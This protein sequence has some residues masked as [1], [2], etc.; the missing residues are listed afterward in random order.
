MARPRTILGL[1]EGGLASRRQGLRAL[2]RRATGG[3]DP[4][5]VHDVRVALRRLEALARLF[6]GLPS[7]GDG[8]EVRGAARELRRRLSLLRSEEVGRALLAARAS[9]EDEA[10][11]A[12][13]FPGDPPSAR[14]PAGELE[15]VERVAAA[16]QRR[17]ATALGRPFSPRSATEAKLLART[18]RRLSRR[19]SELARLLP[20]RVETLHAARIAAKRA[21][22][23][24]EVVEPLVPRAGPL[25]G[26]LRGFQDAA[27]NAH[28]LLELARRVR[29]AVSPGD[30]S[31]PGSF[32]GRLETECA[33]AA[34]SA[35]RRGEA[36]AVP[37]RKLRT[38]LRAPGSR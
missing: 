1:V 9:G 36:L 5:L 30:A 22:Y 35:R 4:E 34:G 37:V 33:K 17:L 24:L 27:G 10:L 7:V 6:R 15:A 11:S 20:P 2:A 32:L 18:R 28:D 12:L 14:V 31:S 13:V 29:N 23:A 26:S 8:R 3:G 21:R 38:A 16:W 25:L 19:L